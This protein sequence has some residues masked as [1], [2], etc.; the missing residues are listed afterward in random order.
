MVT[1]A[2]WEDMNGDKQKDIVLA[3]E[4]G[5]VTILYK[6]GNVF[7]P[8]ELSENGFW[9]FVLPVDIDND[10]D[11][12]LVAGNLG[13]NSRLKAN[14]NQPVSMYFNDFDAN[15]VQEQVLTYYV[16][17]KEIC[18][19]VK[20]DL[21]RQ[22][23]QLKKKFL[24]AEDFAK[25]SL[26]KIFTKEKLASARKWTATETRSMVFINNGE[27]K[28]TAVPLPWQA[29]LS[30]LKAAIARDVNGDGLSDLMMAGNFY[31]NNVQLG[32]NDADFGSMLINK[33]DSKFVV[34]FIPGIRLKG[35]VRK[36]VDEQG[37]IWVI[38]NNEVS[39]IISSNNKK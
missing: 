32:R 12:D 3:K 22:M 33:G 13:E 34:Q 23:P 21:E 28:F 7:K 9:N 11:M 36:L 29:Q 16:G 24:Y 31:E 5:A 37:K 25:A 4:W 15:G 39:T 14:T 30:P 38:K 8:V 20:S 17:G 6:Q 18:F 1:N 27:Q 2:V 10:G 26:E 35:Q 19:A